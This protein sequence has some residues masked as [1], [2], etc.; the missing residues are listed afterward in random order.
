MPDTCAGRVE[1][2]VV[3]VII[4]VLLGEQRIE[5]PG[6]DGDVAQ[7]SNPP[8]SEDPEFSCTES[9]GELDPTGNT[10]IRGAEGNR[11]ANTE[12]PSAEMRAATQPESQPLHPIHVN[13]ITN[14]AKREPR[15][16]KPA[17]SLG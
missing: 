15:W 7:V 1:E 4:S 9:G 14:G 17:Q 5:G 3:A 11:R 12:S 10:L 2:N 13:Q 16:G 6:N 8:L